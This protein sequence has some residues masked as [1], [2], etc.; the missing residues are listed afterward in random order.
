MKLLFSIRSYWSVKVY[1]SAIRL[2][3]DRGHTVVLVS[4][5]GGA[6]RRKQEWEAAA[7]RL[8]T[9][10]PGISC[11]RFPKYDDALQRFGRRLRYGIDYLR[12]SQ[13]E[14]ASAPVLRN[15]ALPTT[16]A[17]VRALGHAPG[18]RTTTGLRA[19]RAALAGLDRC[20]PDSPAAADLLE[21][22]RPDLVLLSPL[23]TLGSPQADVLKAAR[24]M[25]IRTAVAVGSWDHLSS[26]ALIRPVPDLVLVWNSLQRR[27]AVEMHGIPSSRVAATGAQCFDQWFSRVPRRSRQ[28]F[29]QRVGLD[30]ARPTLAYMCSSLF[31]GSPP[32]APF[33]QRWI[34]ELRANGGATLRDCNILVRPHPNR[35]D[36]WKDVELGSG[37][38]VWPPAGAAPMDDET[39]DDYFETMYYADAVVALNTSAMIEAAI[40]RRPIYTVLL[41]EFHENQEGTLHFRY[42][43]TVGGGILRTARTLPAHTAQLAE[44]LSGRAC[45]SHEAFLREFVRPQGLD[46]PST[47]AFV[48][49]LERAAAARVPSSDWL[50]RASYAVRPWLSAV[51]RR[52]AG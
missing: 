5:T 35:G 24:R 21:R 33:V 36:E 42:L 6:A 40:V 44:A 26:K 32:E 8:A 29:F 34:R 7:R 1:E 49:A 13:P 30:P 25:G 10:Y 39:K 16:P 46:V 48:D 28:A 4:S 3:A 2:L 18:L 22:H 20:L 11:E 43:T 31:A 9:E 15:R 12:Y 37:A 27:E 47:P 41:P 45:V 23:I 17:F 38:V 19:L 50:L 52:A 14:Y 51:A